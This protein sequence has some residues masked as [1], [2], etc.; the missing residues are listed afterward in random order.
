MAARRAASALSI[1][2][3]STDQLPRCGMLNRRKVSNGQ[4]VGNGTGFK[5][6]ALRAQKGIGGLQRGDLRLNVGHLAGYQHR[7]LRTIDRIAPLGRKDVA[8]LGERKTAAL[9]T[10]N[11]GQI[12]NGLVAVAAVVVGLAMGHDKP[13]LLVIALC[14]AADFTPALQLSN[15]HSKNSLTVEYA[16]HLSLRRSFKQGF[17]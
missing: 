7:A 5:L 8:D 14:M 10:L 16:L 12:N 13:E 15:I 1:A 3:V 17:R 11:K 6:C 2:A 9:G 4:P